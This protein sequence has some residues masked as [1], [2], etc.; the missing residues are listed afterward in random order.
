[1]KV[2]NWDDAVGAL[3]AVTLTVEDLL[4][5]RDVR[6]I[7]ELID[8]G[9]PGVAFENLCTQLYEYEVTPDEASWEALA[10]I[11]AYF[12]SNPDLWQRLA[13]DS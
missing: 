7:W 6:S 1:M 11:G 3:R 13:T 9:E 5:Q 2:S 10:E 12:R 4:A 8:A